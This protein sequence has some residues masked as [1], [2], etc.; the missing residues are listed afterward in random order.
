MIYLADDVT[1]VDPPRIAFAIPRK[2]G[3]A[4]R[5]NAIRRGVRGRL[6]QRM[7]TDDPRIHPGAYLVAVRAGG[8]A[9]SPAEIA[10]HVDGCLED[11]WAR[12]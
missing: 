3:N 6:V 11:L 12:R 9:A 1:P 2:V 4:V 5:R 10:G 8:E 7:A